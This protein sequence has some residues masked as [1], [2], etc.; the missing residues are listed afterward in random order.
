MAPLSCT[1]ETGTH[2]T[3]LPECDWAAIPHRML[4]SAF[5]GIRDSGS[6]ASWWLRG[7]SILVSPIGIFT[8]NS[9]VKVAFIGTGLLISLPFSLTL[10][11]FLIQWG[12]YTA[13]FVQCSLWLGKFPHHSPHYTTNACQIN[14]PNTLWLEASVN[15]CG[16][17]SGDLL[18]SS[19]LPCQGQG[20]WAL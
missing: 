17:K 14:D 9:N 7:H 4:R 5:N 8:S 12:D 2:D 10:N 3:F 16:G 18:L 6:R 11:L 20:K 1:P 15:L 13:I 19:L